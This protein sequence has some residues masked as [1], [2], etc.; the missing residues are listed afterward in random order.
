MGKPQSKNTVSVRGFKKVLVANRGE[1]AVRVIQAVQQRGLI[2]VAVYSEP[3]AKAKHVQVADEAYALGGNTSAQSYLQGEKIIEL[4]KTHEV[5]AIHPGYG[6]L[7]E[8]ADFA[9]ACAQAGM[10]FIG[11]TP[12]AMEAMGDKI[13]AKAV[14]EKAGVPVVPGFTAEDDTDEATFIKEAQKIGYPILVKASAGGGGKGMR[15]VKAEGELLDGIAAARREAEKSF[16]DPR[17]FLEKYIERPRHIEFQIFG[18]EHGNRVHLFERECSIQRRHQKI[19]EETPSPFL[20]PQLR[21]AMGEAA[22]KAADAIGYTNAGTVE[23]ITAP[24][25]SFYFLEVNTRLQVEHPVTE[26]VTGTDLVAAQLDVA[27]GKPLPWAQDDLTQKGHAFECRIYAEDPDNGFVPSIGPI[28]AY[29]EPVGPNI[30]VDSGIQ[31]GHEVSIYYDPMLAKLIVWGAD[32]EQ[33]MARMQWALSRYVVLGVITNMPFLAQVFAHPVFQSGDI[34]THFLDEHPVGS[35]QP[36]VATLAQLAALAGLSQKAPGSLGLM[37][38]A[39]N[40]NQSGLKSRSD[41]PGPVLAAG[42]RMGGY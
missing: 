24:D 17:I 12:E 2:A 7:S 30:R 19:I 21:K 42:F 39:G 10:T 3:D 37:A 16:G 4:C 23:F 40:T 6:F 34:H 32:R 36:D 26:L 9:R 8:N 15:L 14:M 41:D 5:G 38:V 20:T 27:M 13:R 31:Q 11:P 33:A 28:L 29:D 22:L 1:I 18:D 35:S 25:G